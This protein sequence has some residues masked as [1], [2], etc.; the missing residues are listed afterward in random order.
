MAEDRAA[1]SIIPFIVGVVLLITAAGL[2]Y[3]FAPRPEPQR[4]TVQHIL[5]SFAGTGTAATRSREAAEKFAGE[6]YK[7]AENGEDFGWLVK[8]YSDDPVAPGIYAMCNAEVTLQAGEYN[9]KSM[10]PAF[11]NLGFKLKV[12]RIGMAPYD[13]QA[14]P[15][16]WHILKRL[17]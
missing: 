14:S 7:R 12:G 3:A 17:K 1:G 11:G 16:G 6:I 8:T 5:I 13:P 10:V 2:V 15:Y 9:R 4:V